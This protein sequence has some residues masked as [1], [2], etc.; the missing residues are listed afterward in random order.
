MRPDKAQLEAITAADITKWGTSR[1]AFSAEVQASS[2]R[3][4]AQHEAVP[5]RADPIWPG[6]GQ[7]Q[8]RRNR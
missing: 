8:N 2:K 4:A 1:K 7:R 3:P 6:F 5:S